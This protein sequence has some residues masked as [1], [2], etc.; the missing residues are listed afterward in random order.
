MDHILF[1]T[2]GYTGQFRARP[3]VRPYDQTILAAIR[4]QAG[5]RYPELNCLALIDKNFLCMLF[6]ITQ[7]SQV[8]YAMSGISSNSRPTSRKI[9]RAFSRCSREWVAITPNRMR[10]IFSGTPG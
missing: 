9:S 2:H 4:R 10:S 3:E 5:L 7:I 6:S 1:L 8:V